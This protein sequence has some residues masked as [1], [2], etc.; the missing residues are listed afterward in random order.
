MWRVVWQVCSMEVCTWDGEDTH[1]MNALQSCLDRI[2]TELK[3]VTTTSRHNALTCMHVYMYIHSAWCHGVESHLS[4]AHFSLRKSVSE[5]VL[6]SLA[7][8]FCLTECLECWYT[9]YMYI[10]C[11]YLN[12]GQNFLTTTVVKATCCWCKYVDVWLLCSQTRTTA[13][14]VVEVL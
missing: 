6:H 2:E 11:M 13:G 9:L 8:S 1:N 3:S 5:F 12:I 10:I 14:G 7:L 4:A